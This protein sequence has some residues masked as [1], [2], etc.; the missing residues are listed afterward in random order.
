MVAAQHA[1]FGDSGVP[2][3]SVVGDPVLAGLV[4]AAFDA[5][6]AID[7]HM[8]IQPSAAQA[9][10]IAMTRAVLQSIADGGGDGAG[11]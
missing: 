5:L 3:D 2:W 1:V 6:Q 10:E 11:G 9:G 7:R 4:L 8:G